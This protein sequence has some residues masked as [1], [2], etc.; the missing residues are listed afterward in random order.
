M[1]NGRATAIAVMFT[2]CL[3]SI[4]SPSSAAQSWTSRLKTFRS[5]RRLYS[6]GKHVRAFALY[7]TAATLPTDTPAL[8]KRTLERIN[9]HRMHAML[10]PV[11]PDERIARAAA[12]H[13]SYLARNEPGEKALDLSRAH[14]EQK[15][16][17]GYTGHRLGQRL[18]HQGFKGSGCEV[19]SW[20]CDP[21]RAVDHLVNSIYHRGG[22]LRPDARY[23][24]VG[25]DGR[26]VIDF[27]WA[28]GTATEIDWA[29]YPGVGQQGVPPRFPGGEIPDPL[30]GATYP[31]GSPLS[32]IGPKNAPKV[33][34]VTL[35]GP[36]GEVPVK[37]LHSENIAHGD[38]LGRFVHAMP[39][40][41]LE[42]NARYT[43]DVLFEV[44]GRRWSYRWQ[45]FTGSETPGEELWSARV[46]AL[47]HSPRYIRP[48]TLLHFTAK[49]DATHPEHLQLRWSVDG[50]PMKTGKAKTFSHR[51]QKPGVIEV[52]ARAFYP[53][54]PEAYGRR[55]QKLFILDESGTIPSLHNDVGKLSIRLDF[56]PE[57]PWE[58]G[59]PVSLYLRT[60]TKG[61]DGRKPQFS[62][63]VDD[64]IIG[65]R[66][67]SPK[68]VWRSDGVT[69][70]VFLGKL[71]DG[72]TTITKRVQFKTTIKTQEQ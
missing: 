18:S 32:I 38:L 43:A 25:I 13:A 5:A 50:K 8:Q 71:H 53:D 63:F 7:K 48:G 72:T 65:E 45:F 60:K 70:H 46:V 10:V 17:P 51:V 40:R 19:I 66:S 41:A 69:D 49:V 15:G 68:A 28:P 57:P 21:A 26:T 31:V 11:M 14:R 33:E 9:Y 36:K 34:R 67:S 62:F 54:R 47:D 59:R 23:A 61:L 55:V 24:G 4:G 39:M 30:P 12:A 22:I 29:V 3:F 35:V 37:T 42:C 44:E 52:E 2:V 56:D 58:K 6:Q 27:A 64:T 1:A 16:N 20:E